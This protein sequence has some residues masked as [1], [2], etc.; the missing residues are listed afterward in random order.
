[1]QKLTNLRYRFND[2][3]LLKMVGYPE[4][5]FSASVTPPFLFN[6]RISNQKEFNTAFKKIIWVSYRKD[7]PPLIKYTD[8]EDLKKIQKMISQGKYVQNWS[9]SQDNCSR[10]TQKP[11]GEAHYLSVKYLSSDCGWGCMI[12]CQQ[13][14]LANT[15]RKIV[16]ENSK[17]VKL[18]NRHSILELVSDQDSDSSLFG[19]HNICE[20]GLYLM[21]KQP[22]D[23]YGVNSITQVVK[24]IFTK[25]SEHILQ[26]Q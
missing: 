18:L 7:F 12:R 17:L 6:R 25:K 14:M 5:D 24:E 15:F 21:N 23:W 19:I 11:V 4:V 10:I 1:M 9:G 13:M 16:E 20:T 2:G 8:S 26:S 22:G 3:D